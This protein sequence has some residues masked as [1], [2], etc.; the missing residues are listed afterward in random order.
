M[1][2][3]AIDRPIVQSRADGPTFYLSYDVYGGWNP[4]GCPRLD[5]E[6]VGLG[7]D[8][9]VALVSARHMNDDSM[10]SAFAEYSDE[11]FACEHDEILLQASDGKMKLTVISANAIDSNRELN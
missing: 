1:P 4:Y 8:S 3:T 7:I 11:E 9:P 10:L 2:G 5:A 6:C